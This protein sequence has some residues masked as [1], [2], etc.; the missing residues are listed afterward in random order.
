MVAAVD[1]ILEEMLLDEIAREV[2]SAPGASLR[3]KLRKTPQA[4][5]LEARGYEPW[6]MTLGRRTFKSPFS[7]FHHRFWRWYWPARMKLLRGEQLT[8]DELTALLIWG[9]GLGKSSHV[10]WACIAEGALGEG[11]TEE[12]GFVGYV[13]A[14]SDLAKGHLQSIRNRLLSPEIAHYYPGLANPRLDTHGHQLGFRQ[15]FLATDS[16]WGIV[17]LGLKEGVR[18]GKLLDQRYTMFVFD[19]VDNRKYS[20]DVIRKNLEIIAYEIL[21]AGTPGRTL[22]LFP[23]NLIRDDGV[24]AQILNRES[25]VLSRRTVIG[26]DKDEPQP[27]FDDV[28]LELDD[29]RPGSYRIKSATPV[30]E[31]FDV[32]AA[33]VFLSDSGRSGF[34]AE[35]QHDLTGER[36]EFVLQNFRDEVHVITESQFASPYGTRSIPYYWPKRGFNDWA[37]TNTAKHANVAGFL[38]VS[39]QMRD[40]RTSG[41][42]FLHDCMTFE[43]GTGADEVALRIIKTLS[44]V[45]KV[46]DKVKTWEEVL[47]DALSRENMPDYGTNL[48]DMVERARDARSKVVPALVRPIVRHHKVSFRGSHDENNGALKVYRDVYGLDF[49]STNPG[50]DGGVELLNSLMLVD[51]TRPHLFKPDER[52]EDG[53][54][55]L[56]F[57]RFYM[58]V[59]DD[60]A[61]P[62]PANARPRDLRDSDRA[63][64]QLRKWRELPVKDNETGEVERGP[65]KRNDDFGNGLMMCVHDGLPPTPQLSKDEKFEVENPQFADEQ[66]QRD[67]DSGARSPNAWH[68]KDVAKREYDERHN[69]PAFA[70][71]IAARRYSGT[72]GGRR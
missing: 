61:A 72:N 20:S 67:I 50:A 26:N 11:V 37:K 40:P 44:P 22:K 2:V 39:P 30:W 27:A 24:L 1:D 34:M 13:C 4:A 60:K 17:P 35:F 25:D 15:D 29:E 56:G 69:K 71:P 36:G 51:R 42:V 62:P 53:L 21:P 3:P 28:E 47:S 41:L 68:A 10:E 12:P 54:Y 65:E 57:T 31:G 18:G 7:P 55:K 63:R 14:D 52:E 6:A 49:A 38:S 64:Y 70:S 59:K 33:E 66:I 58:I 5:A 45:A 23:Q 19:D 43:A 46:G 32:N 48:T 9:R 16:G 8:A